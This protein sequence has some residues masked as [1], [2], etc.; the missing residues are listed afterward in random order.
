MDNYFEMIHMI[1]TPALLI[2]S[3][4]TI[5]AV[6]AGAKGSFPNI[7][8]GMSLREACRSDLWDA[9]T[10]YQRR[11]KK[12][13]MVLCDEKGAYS[14]QIIPLNGEDWLA[15]VLLSREIIGVQNMM[16][17]VESFKEPLLTIR[18][19]VDILNRSPEVLGKGDIIDMLRRNISR[20]LTLLAQAT[21]IMNPEYM[22]YPELT[23]CELSTAVDTVTKA[24]S[25]SVAGS[26]LKMITET[27]RGLYVMASVEYLERAVM[28]LISNALK[29]AKTSV[30]VR[31][32]RCGDF[33]CLTVSDDG[34]GIPPE[35]Q[36]Y[37]FAPW[38]SPKLD[39]GFELGYGLMTAKS[40]ANGLK[41]ELS[42]ESG[43]EETKFIFKLPLYTGGT[44]SSSQPVLRA[45]AEFGYSVEAADALRERKT[46]A[47]HA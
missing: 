4:L 41:G 35:D 19:L 40:I 33:A 10:R 26:D 17:A 5:L 29:F 37:I 34:A 9:A 45:S 42:F 21:F 36:P 46:K 2:D 1:S 38:F 43:E 27:S 22:E 3:N 7:Q 31:T 30:T 20:S 32:Y 6:G 23:P 44:F 24:I 15:L 18:N 12:P 25:L 16:R 13:Q 28:S 14:L 47:F 39:E 11:G 8:E